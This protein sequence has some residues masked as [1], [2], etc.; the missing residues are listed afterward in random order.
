MA[1]ASCLMLHKIHG[2]CAPGFIML[3]ADVPVDVLQ[4]R[5]EI[6]MQ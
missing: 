1:Y 2:Q 6:K 3:R 4:V 5:L